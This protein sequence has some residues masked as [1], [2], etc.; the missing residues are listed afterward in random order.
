MNL[1]LIQVRLDST[2][3]PKKALADLA[4]K[5]VL[6][7]IVNRLRASRL[8]D[9]V[10]VATS[11]EPEDEPIRAFAAAGGMDF[12]A[13]DKNDLISRLYGAAREFESD[14]VVRVTGD[15]P[16]VDPRLVDQ[17]IQLYL[18][19]QQVDLVVNTHPPTFPDG[20]D[21]EVLP[22]KT[23]DRLDKE[24]KSPFWREWFTTYVADPANGFN[25]LNLA[26]PK[27]LSAM[28]WTLDYQEDL[29]FLKEIYCRLGRDNQVFCMT[30]VL[31]LLEETPELSC[32]N[33]GHVRNEGLE[34]AVRSQGDER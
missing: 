30:D 29:D 13:G 1:G 18:N 25:I 11:G 4:G 34:T 15:C 26:Y 22:F 20:L 16:L 32:I 27:D 31:A 24:V 28:R 3:L 8:L 2:R 12:Y 21:L 6:W 17:M 10:V 7:H 23:L 14:V 19:N 9:R 5:P 33:Q